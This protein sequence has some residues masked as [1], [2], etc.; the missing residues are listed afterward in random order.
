M[1]QSVQEDQELTEKEVKE[2]DQRR[3]EEK[4]E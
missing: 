2:R 1:K 4:G 3:D